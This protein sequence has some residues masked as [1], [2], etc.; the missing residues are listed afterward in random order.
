MKSKFLTYAFLF[1]VLVVVFQYVNS[2]QII[3][4]YE[5]DIKIY[6]DRIEQ[7]EVQNSELESK[8]ELILED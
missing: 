1:T 8:L 7:L 2:K 3:D 6:K 5:K 4:K